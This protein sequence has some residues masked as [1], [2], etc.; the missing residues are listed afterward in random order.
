[1][2]GHECFSPAHSRRN[3]GAMKRPLPAERRRRKIPPKARE[4]F[5]DA[6]AAG[7]SVRRAANLTTHAFQRWYELLA[8]RLKNRQNA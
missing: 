8:D 5:L 3:R 4:Q 6:L 1:M 7:W 2:K